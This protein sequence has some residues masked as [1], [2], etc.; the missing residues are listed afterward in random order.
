MVEVRCDNCGF[1][2]DELMRVHEE[3]WCKLCVAEDEADRL[4]WEEQYRKHPRL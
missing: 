2:T 4:W 1:R 3:D